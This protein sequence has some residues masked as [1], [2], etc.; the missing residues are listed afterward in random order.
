M[1]CFVGLLVFWLGWFFFL[2]EMELSELHPEQGQEA[3]PRR[4]FAPL[5]QLIYRDAGGYW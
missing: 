1:A 2:R 5:H 4:E 3:K